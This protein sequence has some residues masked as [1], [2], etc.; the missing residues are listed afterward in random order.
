MA[1]EQHFHQQFGTEIR[2]SITAIVCAQ[3]DASFTRGGLYAPHFLLQILTLGLQQHK[4]WTRHCCS[5]RRRQE[6][7]NHMRVLPKLSL[8][9]PRAVLWQKVKPAACH[10]ELIGGDFWR[11]QSPGLAWRRQHKVRALAGGEMSPA[12]PR[13]HHSQLP[14]ASLGHVDVLNLLMSPVI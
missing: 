1:K 11:L 14:T 9:L 5:S 7:L 12:W 4:R 13:G 6:F 10:R 8:N 2:G 3:W